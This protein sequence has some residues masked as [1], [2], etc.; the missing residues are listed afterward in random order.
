MSAARAHFIRRHEVQLVAVRSPAVQG[1]GL[2]AT[3]TNEAARTLRSGLMVQSYASL[4]TFLRERVA[5]V[6]SHVAAGTSTFTRLPARLQDLS[7]F[8]ALEGLRFRVNMWGTTDPRSR[9]LVQD[10]AEAIA[11]TARNPYGFSGMMF[12]FDRSN[13]SPANLKEFLE[14]MGV[15]GN[16]WYHLTA[17]ASRV[18]LGGLPLKDGVSNGYQRRN[19]SAHDADNQVTPQQIEDFLRDSLATALGFDAFVSRAARLLYQGNTVGLG[20]QHEAHQQ[21]YQVSLSRSAHRWL[22][23][24]QGGPDESSSP[25][26]VSTSRHGRVR[27]T[28]TS[29]IRGHSDTRRAQLASRLEDD[30][31]PI[32]ASRPAPPGALRSARSLCIP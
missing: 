15:D 29:G 26:P 27:S 19:A 22:A 24:G 16:P 20:S 13:L 7:I 4:E 23:G 21:R 8:G 30:R 25:A 28:G 18:G 2:A 10:E 31:L 1:A 17:I 3:P 6:M 5:E 9:Q 32:G 12:G 11:S 14:V